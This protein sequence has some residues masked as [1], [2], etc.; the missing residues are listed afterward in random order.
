MLSDSEDSSELPVLVLTLA[1][2]AMA[3]GSAVPL[4]GIDTSLYIYKS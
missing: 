3:L 1:V 4:A 2:L